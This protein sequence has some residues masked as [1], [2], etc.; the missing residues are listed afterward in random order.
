MPS[1]VPIVARCRS[2]LLLLSLPLHSLQGKVV[3]T[4]NPSYK[5]CGSRPRGYIMISHTFKRRGCVGGGLQCGAGTKAFSA[6]GISWT[7]ASDDAFPC[8]LPPPSPLRLLLL[9]V[10]AVLLLVVVL[11]LVLLLLLVWFSR[12]VWS[13]ALLRTSH[14]I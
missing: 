10:A 9:V 7:Y 14:L 12:C 5:L 3:S 11:L 2:L 6:D 13:W 8:A 1:L 4:A